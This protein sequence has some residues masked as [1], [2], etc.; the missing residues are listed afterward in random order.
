MN[1]RMNA[2]LI[3]MR[4]LAGHGAWRRAAGFWLLVIAMM[5][6]FNGA[7]WA[8]SLNGFELKGSLIPIDQIHQG[9]P[10]RDGIPSIDRPH[11]IA[12]DQDYFLQPDSLVIGLTLN[13]EARAYPIAILNWHELVNDRIGDRS[14]VVSYCP[15]CGTGMVFSADVDGQEL[16]FGVS[17]LLYN[18]DLLLY[19]RQRES[20]WSQIDGEAISGPFKGRKLKLFPSTLTSWQRWKLQHPETELL[21][22]RTGYRRDYLRSP[23]GDYD[24]N[25]RIYFPV[26]FLSRRYHPKERVLGIALGGVQ[27]AYPF[28]ELAK[29]SGAPILSDKVAGKLLKIEY[30]LPSRSGRITDQQGVEI[31]VINSFWFAWYGFHPDT[32]VWQYPAKAGEH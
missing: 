22:T 23:Y 28:A 26:E 8:R 1:A 14:V 9:G 13:G 19:D 32:E 16:Q 27:K 31:A 17:G 29:R 6:G 10:P 25:E 2:L 3:R 15:L 20:L 7:A 11:F 30:D 5:I 21:S 24:S 12:A 4:R 18:S